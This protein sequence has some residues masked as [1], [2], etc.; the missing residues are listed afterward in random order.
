MLSFLTF[1]LLLQEK[2]VADIALIGNNVLHFVKEL[3]IIFRFGVQIP[4]IAIK[5]AGNNGVSGNLSKSASSFLT[6]Y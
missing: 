1:S 5:I 4:H 6:D 3:P 2:L